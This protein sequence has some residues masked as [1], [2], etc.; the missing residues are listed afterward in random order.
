MDEFK[1]LIIGDANHQYI[2]NFSKWLRTVIPNLSVT[3]ISFHSIKNKINA[4]NHF[5]NYFEVPANSKILLKIKVFRTLYLA[6]KLYELIKKNNL[7]ADTILV[8]YVLPQL[9]YIARFLKKR[10]FNYSLAIW[11]SD[12]YRATPKSYFKT[13]LKFADHIIIGSPQMFED[14]KYNYPF[15]KS[16]FHLCYF[17]NEP[18]EILKKFKELNIT[19]HESCDIF[20]LTNDKIN[21]T[22][23]HNGSNAHRHTFILNELRLLRSDIL[24]KIRVLLPMTYGLDNNYLNEV[25]LALES[26]SFEYKIFTEFMNETEVAHLRNITDIMVNL[27]ITDGFSGSMREVLYCGGIVIN[28]SWLPYNFLKEIGINFDEIDSCN[29]VSGKLTNIIDN[30]QEL[31]KECESNA[32]LIYGISSWSQTIHSWKEVIEKQR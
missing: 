12:F 6:W 24:K 5:D 25:K 30:F 8:H 28:G 17:G 20:N 29:E 15:H 22:V 31:R 19:K 1:L 11:G 21:I 7:R 2:T 23:G 18:V 26:C 10:S 27:Q 32:Y 16:K 3:I 13:N 4:G 9:V 14:F